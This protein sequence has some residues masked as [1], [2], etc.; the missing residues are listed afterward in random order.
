MRNRNARIIH[1]MSTLK[2]AGAK[3]W[4]EQ[5][6]HFKIK[7]HDRRGHEQTL[8][9]SRSP[10]D[11]RAGRKSARDLRRMIEATLTIAQQAA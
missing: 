6:K 7:W 4:L 5:G 1:A 2:A 3:P 9:M 11:W 10:S 8:V